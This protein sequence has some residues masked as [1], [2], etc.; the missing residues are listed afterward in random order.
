MQKSDAKTSA[1]NKLFAEEMKNAPPEPK[2]S[3]LREDRK[4]GRRSTALIDLID[5]GGGLK[6]HERLPSAWNLKHSHNP[7]ENFSNM[8]ESSTSSQQSSNKIFHD[9]IQLN[10]MKSIMTNKFSVG[11][12][13]LGRQTKLRNHN[14]DLSLCKDSAQDS[15]Q[16]R[17]INNEPDKINKDLNKLGSQRQLSQ[18]VNFSHVQPY[19]NQAAVRKQR[20]SVLSIKKNETAEPLLNY[21]VLESNGQSSNMPKSAV[22]KDSVSKSKKT[23]GRSLIVQTSS[24]RD[25]QFP[26]SK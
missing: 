1:L 17:D 15:Q 4:I 25:Q 19:R 3:L 7:S 12:R 16:Q 26:P 8:S 2:S 24:I 18:N 21:L 23:G 6:Q 22:R 11:C 13:K 20:T 5:Q 14:E 9:N 10:K